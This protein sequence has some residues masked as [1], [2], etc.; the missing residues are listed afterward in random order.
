M[1]IILCTTFREFKENEND[2]L[3]YAFL[4]SIKKQSYQDFL[5]VTTTF[6]EKNVKGVVD[7]YFG[8]KSIVKNVDVPTEF[9]FSLTDVVLSAIEVAEQCDDRSIIVWCTCDIVVESSFFQKLVDNYVEGVSGIVH[10]N[11]IYESIDALN[12]H[13]GKVGL[14]SEG[15]DL[16]FFDSA[17]LLKAR[18]D[19]CDYRFYDWGVFEYFLVALSIG[20]SSLRVNLFNNTKIRKI[21]NDREL[22][23]ETNDYF[24]RCNARN[25]PILDKYVKAKGIANN[26]SNIICYSA[27]ISYIMKS[28]SFFYLYVKAKYVLFYTERGEELRAKY[29]LTRVLDYFFKDKRVYYKS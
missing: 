20:Y 9:R 3:Q 22:T 6:G 28:F 13:R 25:L 17:V 29:H 12:L 21:V 7:G 10:P 11:I 8:E 5:F 19:V 16:L 26:L 15:I 4:D 18:Q 14:L 1:K 23:E 2:Q 24:D 27:H